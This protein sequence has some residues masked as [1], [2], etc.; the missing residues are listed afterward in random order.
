M[1]Y[2]MAAKFNRADVLAEVLAQLSTLK[3]EKLTMDDVGVEAV[4]L[5]YDELD[6]RLVPESVESQLP[7]WSVIY[8][9][10]IDNLV[11]YVL[12][13]D[14]QTELYATGIISEGRLLGKEGF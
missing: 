11:G 2:D 9:L 3:G 4:R 14:E 8:L 10:S 6:L 12:V 7:L 1:K 13:D 5:N